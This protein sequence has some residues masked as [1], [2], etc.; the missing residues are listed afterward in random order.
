M[1]VYI[2]DVVTHQKYRI[3]AESKD[4]AEEKAMECFGSVNNEKYRMPDN[5]ED[6]QKG[7]FWWQTITT[8]V[9]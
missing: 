7:G 3:E 8:E 2:V 4:A 5:F 9:D 1:P 6:P